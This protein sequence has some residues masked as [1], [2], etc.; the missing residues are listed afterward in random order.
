MAELNNE[1]EN[2]YSKLKFSNITF[3]R[4]YADYEKGGYSESLKTAVQTG[5]ASLFIPSLIYI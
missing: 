5:L 4:Y 1:V 2:I 3:M